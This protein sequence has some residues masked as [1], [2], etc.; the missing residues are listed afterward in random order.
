MPSCLGTVLK[1]LK[2]GKKETSQEAQQTGF[3]F[4]LCFCTQLHGYYHFPDGLT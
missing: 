2:L 4:M 3:A 1:M